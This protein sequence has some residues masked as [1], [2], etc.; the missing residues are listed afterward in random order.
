MGVESQGMLLAATGRD[1][2]LSILT[3]DR[4]VNA[5]AGIK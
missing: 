5:G 3:L 2:K 4:E 1:G